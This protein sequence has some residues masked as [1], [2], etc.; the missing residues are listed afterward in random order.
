MKIKINLIE[1]IEGHAGFVGKI[2]KGKMNDAKL[3]VHQ[4]ARLI[5][6]IL[7]GRKYDDVPIITSRICGVCPVAHS[8][9]S[10]KALEKCFN[11]EVPDGVVFLRRL[12]QLGQ[13]IQSHSLHA[14]FFVSPDFLGAKSSFDIEEKEMLH[15]MIELKGFSNDM[16]EY[17]GGRISH[18]VT[19]VVSGFTAVPDKKK[20]LDLR[21]RLP[22]IKKIA[23]ELFEIFNSFPYPDFKRETEYIALQNKHSYGL[24]SGYIVSNKGLEMNPTD[25]KTEFKE[26]E[27]DYS[28]AKFSIHGRETFMVGALSRINLNNEKLN[29]SAKKLLR[30]SCINLPEFNTFK[31]TV[32]QV[33]EIIHC[34]EETEKLL[35]KIST[36]KK[37][38]FLADE[39]KVKAGI[40]V[41]VIEAPRG[42]LYHTYET[43]K[44]GRIVHAD[45]VTP[46][47]Q[48]LANLEKDLALYLPSLG[49][50]SQKEI[51]NQTKIL[52]RAYD[53]CISCSTH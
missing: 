42:T 40:G 38:K 39:V 9:A 15:K 28:T 4:G 3:E 44:E 18:P 7:I 11:I 26:Y 17:I 14:F 47:A 10:I 31:N 27:K 43:N 23:K 24:Y 21:K 52:I 50:I 19:L 49:K 34:L 5:E 37:E 30:K 13:I 35:D 2:V 46:T 45:I 41:G 33:I 25:Y 36:A 6:G 1:K 16:M 32:A 8:L 29:P 48:F 51:G 53:P 20:F 22:K 12:I